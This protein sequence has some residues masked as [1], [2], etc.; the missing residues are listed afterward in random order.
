MVFDDIM[1]K[2][3]SASKWGEGV[4]KIILIDYVLLALAA[5]VPLAIVGGISRF[6]PG[7]ST[8]AQRSWTM[9]WMVFSFFTG[10]I[11]SRDVHFE[12][13]REID[14]KTGG[15]GMQIPALHRYDSIMTRIQFLIIVFAYAAPALGGFVVV[16]QEMASYGVCGSIS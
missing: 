10:V 8:H 7:D 16:G 3:T 4:Y 11:A 14:N 9:T 6:R 12:D 13:W 1:A 2:A 5:S 15:F